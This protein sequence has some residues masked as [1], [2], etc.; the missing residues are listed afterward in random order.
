MEEALEK[1]QAALEAA[2]SELAADILE[3]L[4]ITVGELPF[5]ALFQ[6]ADADDDEAHTRVFPAKWNPV[7][8][9]KRVK[10]MTGAPQGARKLHALLPI[11]IGLDTT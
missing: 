11:R 1:S 4:A 3:A 2:K 10:S 9:R 7:C 5:R 8:R 6:A